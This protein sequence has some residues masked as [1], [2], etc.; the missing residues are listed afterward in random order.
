[1]V[2][3]LGHK[4]IELIAKLK[5]LEKISDKINIPTE[6]I[7]SCNAP[8][9]ETQ[10]KFRSEPYFQRFEIVD[11]Q[12]YFKSAEEHVFNC[13]KKFAVLRPDSF[14]WPLSDEDPFNSPELEKFL[15]YLKGTQEKAVLMNWQYKDRFGKSAECPTIVYNSERPSV[16][17]L[18]LECGVLHAPSKIGSWALH[19]TVLDQERL[20]VWEY[21]LS[22]TVLFT[23]SAFVLFLATEIETNFGF[24]NGVVFY[25]VPNPTDLDLSSQWQKYFLEK[26]VIFQEDYTFGLLKIFSDLELRG[27]LTWNEISYMT[28]SDAQR[29]TLPVISDIEWRISNQ[30]HRALY[31]PSERVGANSLKEIIDSMTQWLSRNDVFIENM[32]IAITSEQIPKKERFI[33]CKRVHECVSTADE[34]NRFKVYDN[35]KFKIYQLSTHFLTVPNFIDVKDCVRISHVRLNPPLIFENQDL[36]SAK[37]QLNTQLISPEFIQQAQVFTNPSDVNLPRFFLIYY[38]LNFYSRKFGLNWPYRT[39]ARR[40]FLRIFF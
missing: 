8:D 28:I 6:I 9:L 17:E 11:N 12:S 40:V 2:C 30:C 10:K 15:L 23:H 36:P 3:T 34:W 7:L 25:A 21:W 29:G 20:K 31:S 37:L 27:S 1:M 5:V 16:K 22:F 35:G 38:F 4:N 14:L 39:L 19:S 32:R 24:Y 26:Q 18:I 33:A 13:L